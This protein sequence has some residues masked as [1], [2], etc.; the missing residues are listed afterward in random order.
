MRFDGV[1][2]KVTLGRDLTGQ[3]VEE[4]QLPA[5]DPWQI[6]FWE[7]VTPGDGPG[8]PLLDRGVILRA[9]DKARGDD[10][11]TIKL[12]PCRRSQLTDRWLATT[13]GKTGGEEWELKLEA[14][15]SGERRVLAA[16]YSYDRPGGLV[17][18]AGQ[19][20]RPVQDLFTADQLLF[21]QDCSGTAINLATLTAL[22]PVTAT[23]WKDVPAAPHGLDPR[24]ERWTVGDLDFLELSVV[25]DLGQASR[26]QAELTAFL[27]SRGLAIGAQQ[28]NKTRQVLEHL[29]AR[30][31]EPTSTGRPVEHR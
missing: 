12:R 29:M 21:L 24:A 4:L 27:W 10:D 28:Q 2:I 22:P 31:V 15:W 30:A 17:R 13:K 19:G 6:W 7:D 20:N 16:S 25:A 5:E 3:A 23:R 18:E 11:A 9:R 26:R 8:T 1:E 14:D